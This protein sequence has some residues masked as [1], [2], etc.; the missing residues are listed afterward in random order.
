MKNRHVPRGWQFSWISQEHRS[1]HFYDCCQSKDERELLFFIPISCKMFY[2]PAIYIA[3]STS[4]TSIV[5]AGNPVMLLV[6]PSIKHAEIIGLLL[7]TGRAVEWFLEVFTDFFDVFHTY[8]YRWELIWEVQQMLYSGIFVTL[9]Y[10]ILYILWQL[11]C[12]VSTSR[13]NIRDGRDA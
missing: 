9:V 4:V 7:F 10:S 2:W 13:D 5:S 8:S 3:L 1:G 12:E 6:H 11:L